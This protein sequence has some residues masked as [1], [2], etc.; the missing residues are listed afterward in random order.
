MPTCIA[1][2]T[3]GTA[4]HVTPALAVAEAARR[5][6]PDARLLFLGSTGGFEAR[7]V[8]AHGHAFTPLPAAP[9]HG[10]GVGGRL[11]AGERLVAGVAA[12][13]RALRATGAQLVIG[14]GG[15]ATAGAIVAARSLGVPAILHEANAR[16]GL[17]NRVLGRLATRICV[18][19][20]NAAAA[21]PRA[22]RVS[23][24][25][26]PIR[27]ELA[28][29]AAERRQPPADGRLRLLVCGGSLGSPF[30]NCRMPELA[31]ALGAAGI[32]VE[33]W[34]QA[35]ARPLDDVRAA[36]AAA[37]IAARVEAHVDEMAAAY[38]WADVAVA[39]AGAATL[40]EIA[41]AGLPAVLV[42][43]APASD[44]HQAD[45]AA[46][47]AAATGAPWTRESEWNALALAAALAPLARDPAQWQ[48]QSHRIHTLARP[49]AADA[50]VSTCAEILSAPPRSL[51]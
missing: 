49:D 13:R 40:A 7:L 45:N 19:W 4:G 46:A 31:A 26:M 12:A 16:P 43:Y 35:G 47:F 42:P 51:W 9:W 39:C 50:V 17:S 1:L 15:Y 29:L 41:A 21:F 33:A 10:V 37:G 32:A 22:A 24:T 5:R 44:D 18:A 48:A 8:A 30:L 2:A 11:R 25:G 28:A 6:W 27:A 36:Y 3:G 14:F 38:R 23:H 34:H 20:P